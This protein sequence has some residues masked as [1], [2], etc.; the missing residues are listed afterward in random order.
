MKQPAFFNLVQEIQND[1]V[2]QS[3][4]HNRHSSA[5]LQLSITLYRLGHCHQTLGEIAC[6][7]GIGERTVQLFFD[8]TMLAIFHLRPQYLWWPA[9]ESN[10]HIKMR[11]NMEKQSHFPSWVGYSD[12]SIIGLRYKP[13]FETATYWSGRKHF[14]A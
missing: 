8:W 7:F 11:Q 2:L 9:V 12:G 5:S 14:M 3:E 1:T 13:K 4:S 6:L 10:A